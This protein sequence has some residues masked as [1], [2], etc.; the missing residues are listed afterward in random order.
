MAGSIGIRLSEPGD[1]YGY[2]L[3][4]GSAEVSLLELSNGYRALASGGHY[5]AARLTRQQRVAPPRA[6]I[7]AGAAWIVGD[8]LSDANARAATFGT[9]SV[10]ATPFWT[11]VKTGTSK[12]M[13]D[14]W[15]V[16]WSQRYT[17]GVWVG[18]ASGEPMHDVSG[19]SGAAPVWAAVMREL[20]R[21]VT[22]RQ[23]TPAGGLVAAW[24]Q[25]DAPLESS[26]REWFLPGTEQPSFALGLAQRAPALSAGVRADKRDRAPTPAVNRIVAPADRTILA[27]DPDIPPQHQRVELRAAAPGARWQIDGRF[28]GAGQT[29]QWFPLPGRHR[30]QLAD[31]GGRV[32]DSVSLE[33]RGAGLPVP[34]KR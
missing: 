5:S 9:E 8:I 6:A 1:F 24:V 25:I 33:V 34:R 16:G 17:V 12:D 23:P 19:T 30:L 27:L 15:A 2:G 22:S 26:R 10:L 4:L 21:G 13:R 20:H 18:N 3:A 11:A 29:L 31:A 32:L 7:D 28:I 14:N